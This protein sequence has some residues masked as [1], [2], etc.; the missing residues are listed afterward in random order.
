MKQLG[1]TILNEKFF[2]EKT[3][4]S[5]E[6]SFEKHD[7]VEKIEATYDGSTATDIEREEMELKLDAANDEKNN[8]HWM[9]MHQ[10]VE[11][12]KNWKG[13]NSHI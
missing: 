5:L 2:S 10:D 3:M 9:A 1:N 6:K 8:H 12:P 13:F 11:L 4:D 7:E